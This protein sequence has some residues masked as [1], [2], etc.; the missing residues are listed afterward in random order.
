MP[1][2]L[3]ERLAF[4]LYRRENDHVS[5][6]DRPSLVQQEIRA[7]LKTDTIPRLITSH[8]FAMNW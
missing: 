4:P 1:L 7:E 8:W 6:L 2:I 3:Y 5:I